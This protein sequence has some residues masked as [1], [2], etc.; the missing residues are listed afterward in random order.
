MKIT[1]VTSLKNEGPYV[2]EWV[3]HH[4]ALG[5]TDIVVFENDSDDLTDAI[6][7]RLQELGAVSHH[8]NPV[9]RGS[10][11]A[12]AWQRFRQMD[13]YAGSDWVFCCDGDEFLVPTGQD[14]VQAFLA[15]HEAAEAVAVNWRNFGSGGAA[16]WRNAPLAERF[17][18]CAPA[19]HPANAHFKSFH[20]PRAGF[21][22]FG[23]HR[24]W[25]ETPRQGFVYADGTP[26]EDAVQMG[27]QP[28]ASA[29]LA[30]RHAR[31]ALNHYSVKSRAEFDRKVIRGD[32]AHPGAS[33]AR[34][35]K[36]RRLDTNGATNADIDR[37][38]P[39]TRAAMADL[40]ADPALFFLHAR[41]CAHHVGPGS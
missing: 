9:P 21:R 8:P 34:N 5:F 17:R 36:F 11:Q 30:D 33:Y 16:A 13:L 3:A 18:R 38:L 12:R 19:A 31:C 22:A 6:L 27:A 1:L 14:S 29:A 4:R 7:R 25:P 26:V 37:F 24:P 32:G 10:P 35:D 20:R 28:A 2:I 40:L 15:Q 39:A 41:S 23:I